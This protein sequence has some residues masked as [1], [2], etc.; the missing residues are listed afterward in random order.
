ME[1][2]SVVACDQFTDDAE[3]WRRVNEYVGA[4]PSTLRMILPEADIGRGD[5]AERID[6]I[7]ETM[8]EYMRGGIFETHR[9]AVFYVEREQSGGLKRRGIICALDLTQYD[10]SPGSGSLIRATEK[11]VAERIPPRVAIREG[12]ALELPHVVVFIDDAKN[13]V[14]EPLSTEKSEMKKLYGFS[15]MEGG[16][17]IDGWEISERQKARLFSDVGALEE[18]TPMLY[19]VGDG[20]HSL[21]AAKALYEK[22]REGLSDDEWKK[23]PS[24]FALAEIVSLRD[25]AIIFKSIH[26]ALSGV[27]PEL[28][29]RALRPL[30]ESAETGNI[31]W[32]TSGGSG[33][34][35]FSDGAALPTRALQDFLDAYV[36]KNGGSVHYVHGG[37][38][39][40]KLCR[41]GNTIGFDLP[42]SGKGELFSLVME[43]GPL[44]RKTFSVGRATD[45]RY[46]LESRRIR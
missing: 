19:A 46:Y 31:K 8:E 38:A 3:Y 34:F 6:R 10:Y 25:P 27:E 9:G 29:L 36:E 43:R 33:S 32:M 39:L 14:I 28:V 7:D 1:K 4:A 18:N 26:R 24:R 40:K 41:D 45:K 35:S 13:R 37:A 21:A 12:A 2:W 11:T 20:N 22:Q 23:L 17:R 16:G 5:V 42:D 44:P 15:L 30:C